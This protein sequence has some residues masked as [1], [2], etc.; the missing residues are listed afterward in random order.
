MELDPRTTAVLAT[1]FQVDIVGRDGAFADFFA[2]MV[3]Q[4]NV[5]ARA[6]EIVGAAREAGA[7]VAHARVIYSAGHP[8]LIPNC[9][10][11]A[12]VP[13]MDC[14]VDGTPG[15]AFV[16]EMQPQDGETVYDHHRVNPTYGTSL[17]DDLRAGGID[18]VVVFGVATNI[19][20]EAAARSLS[21]DGFR[22]I[23]A[24]D[25]STAGG[26]PVHDASIETLG[27]LVSEISDA[28]SVGAAL[29]AGVP[30]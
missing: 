20:V 18:T 14:L 11:L 4:N 21:D 3:E 27:L 9:P 6:A 17:A 24:A 8:E 1:H 25:A 13:Q 22:V 7:T 19:A 28:G 16:P 26:Q 10:L 29:K 30:A 15:G 5:I 2:D 23:V 12:M